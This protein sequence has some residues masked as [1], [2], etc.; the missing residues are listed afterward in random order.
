M[1]E[2]LPQLNKRHKWLKIQKDFKI[3]DVVLVLST[4]IG[5]GKWQIARILDVFPGKD[6][7]IRVVKVKIDDSEYIRPISKLCPLECDT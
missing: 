4:D 1:K 7:H 5:R 2:W 3:G 6:G